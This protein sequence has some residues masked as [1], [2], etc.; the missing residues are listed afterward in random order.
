MESTLPS[1]VGPT[2]L[3][4]KEATVTVLTVLAVLEA[5]A[6]LVVTATPR[7][8]VRHS[9]SPPS[10]TFFIISNLGFARRCRSTRASQLDDSWPGKRTFGSCKVRRRSIDEREDG[11]IRGR[12][13]L[14]SPWG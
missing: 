4:D 3:Q 11:A 12:G 13:G 5:M 10:A 9:D 8:L 14:L 2:K 1:F 6:V 7:P